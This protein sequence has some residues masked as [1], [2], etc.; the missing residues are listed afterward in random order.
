MVAEGAVILAD[1][2]ETIILH[3]ALKILQKISYFQ[4]FVI[5][6]RSIPS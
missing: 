1:G 3:F 4:K 6:V 5:E 2:I